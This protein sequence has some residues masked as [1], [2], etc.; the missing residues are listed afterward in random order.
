MDIVGNRSD[1]R[2]FPLKQKVDLNFNQGISQFTMPSLLD[3]IYDGL[4]QLTYWDDENNTYISST[5][6]AFN[7][8]FIE[9]IKYSPGVPEISDSAVTIQ[10][11]FDVTLSPD[12]VSLR[13]YSDRSL[14]ASYRMLSMDV[15]ESGSFETKH[16]LIYTSKT[17]FYTTESD[18]SSPISYFS[19][20]YFM[21]AMY[22]NGEILTGDYYYLAPNVLEGQDISILDYSIENGKSKLVLY[23]QADTSVFVKVRMSISE[24]NI[25]YSIQDTVLTLFDVNGQYEQGTEKINTYYYDFLPVFGSSTLKIIIDPLA[26]NDS[27][28]TNN[29]M[30]IPIEN[31][32]LWT[33]GGHFINVNKDTTSFPGTTFKEI[34]PGESDLFKGATYINNYNRNYDLSKFGATQAVLNIIYINSSEEN[35]DL[36]GSILSSVIDDGKIICYLSTELDQFYVLP[37]V[38]IDSLYYF[39]IQKPGYYLLAYSNENIAPNIELNIN[40]RE[41]LVGGYVSERSDFSVIIKDNYGVNPLTYYWDI[42]LDGEELPDD[43]VSQL[44]G[45]DINEIG[46]NFKLNMDI[47]EHTLQVIAHDLVGNR[48][49]TEVYDI[50]YTGESQLINY[51][52][53]PNPFTNRTTFIYELTEQFDDVTIKIFTLAGQKIFT[54]SVSENAIT[55]LPLYSIGYHEIPWYGKDEF[56]NT[57]AN[58]VYFY[59]IEGIID[60][61]KVKSTGK[62]AKLR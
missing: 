62:I 57:V 11:I 13:V 43:N 3:N 15:V 36:K 60:D 38:Q 39:P 1:E 48:A 28:T 61:N 24:S 51:G 42:L 17:S 35:I 55:D 20:N 21:P 32:W 52:N 4:I 56:G 58:G 5:S 27:D 25:E 34:L 47:G 10:I 16:K 41:V 50:I 44:M 26:I 53:F 37:N 18:T 8:P 2:K 6:I 33:E 54:M 14:D 22:I 23:N 49:E 31:K 46:I 30:E 12:S 19:G 29:K 7:A 40:A 59:I 9:N 45:D